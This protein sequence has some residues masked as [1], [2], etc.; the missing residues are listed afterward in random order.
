MLKGGLTQ[1]EYALMLGRLGY[2]VIPLCWPSPTGDCACGWNHKVK[3]VGKAPRVPK[4]VKD[5][6]SEAPKIKRLWADIPDANIGISLDGLVVIDPDSDEA[7]IEAEE[8]G[9]PPTLKRISRFDAYIYKAPE[10]LPSARLTHRGESGA[11][12]VLAGG[13]VVAH[14]VHRTGCE[15]TLQDLD[16]NPADAPQWALDWINNWAESKVMDSTRAEA[17]GAPPVRLRATEMKW[18]NGTN[19]KDGPNGVDRSATLYHIALLL[20]S[21]NASA[22]VIA[23]AIAERD[24]ALGYNK[25]SDRSD[26]PTRYL[27]I[28]HNAIAA[29]PVPYVT[30]N[31]RETG[32][33]FRPLPAF[34]V[35][36]LP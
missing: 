24:V 13:Y 7:Q 5:A 14:G 19:S 4:G 15:V 27:E 31:S 2:R 22:A 8:L 32:H 1:V 18:W 33:I 30:R 26:G 28:A 34:T 6:S 23:E 20:A 9:I 29:Q 35:T 21:A 3:E 16:I 11:I 36:V 10:G 25:Y 12:D 17:Q